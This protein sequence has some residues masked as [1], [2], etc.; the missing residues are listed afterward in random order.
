MS[1]TNDNHFSGRPATFFDKVF[2]HYCETKVSLASAKLLATNYMSA[3]YRMGLLDPEKGPTLPG[4]NRFGPEASPK[5]ILEAY[6]LD[7]HPDLDDAEFSS[8]L[9]AG[10]RAAIF[11]MACFHFSPDN[12]RQ[13]VTATVS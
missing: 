12:Y 5:S 2:L 10:L 9:E 3:L 1:L 8:Q 7:R 6:L 4:C 11:E 13:D